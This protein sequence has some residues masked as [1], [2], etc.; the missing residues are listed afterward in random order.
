MKKQLIHFKFGR[1]AAISFLLA[2]YSIALLS[3]PTVMAQNADGMGVRRTTD[4]IMKQQRLLASSLATRP[5]RIKVESEVDQREELPQNPLSPATSETSEDNPNGDAAKTKGTFP[6]PYAPQTTSLEFTGATL[7]D[8]AAFPPDTMGAIGPTQFV[9][10]V[11]GRIRT[12]NKTTGVADG[13]LDSDMD[14]FF[15]LVMTPDPLNLTFT[16]DPHVRYDRLSGRW[17]VIIIDVQLL[18]E[19]NNRVLLAVSDSETITGSTVWTFFYFQQNLVSPAG[20]TG[21]LA[22]YPTLGID[23]NALYI[24]TNQFCPLPTY[25]SS[26]GF[27]VQKSS[28]LGAGPIVVHAFRNLGTASAAGLYTPQGVDNF[29]AS[30]PYGYFIG[31][32]TQT[33]GTLM[34]RRVSNAGSTSPTISGNIVVTVPT[35]FFPLNVPHKGNT[36]GTTGYLDGIDDRLFAAAI[37]NGRLWTAHNIGVNSSGVATSSPTR[38]AMRWYEIQNLSSTPSLRQS[39]TIFNNAGSD[40]IYYWMGTVIVSGQGHAAF[41]MSASNNSMYPSAATVGRLSGDSLGT[42]QGTPV[43]YEAGAG[44]YNPPLDDGSSSGA[45][46]WGDFSYTSLDPCDDMTMWTIQEYT[47]AT[48]SYGVRAVKLLAPPPAVLP[49]V[50]TA[51]VPTGVASTSVTITGTSPAGQGFYDPGAGFNCRLTAGVT[52]G[53]VVNS[54]TYTNPTSISLNLSTVAASTG[55]ATVTITNP[56]GQQVITT[57]QLDV[58]PSNDNF[59]NATIVTEGAPFIDTSNVSAATLEVGD[60]TATC[61]GTPAG[62]VW[63][64]YTSL[65][66]NVISLNTTGSD[67][68]T[69]LSV[70]TGTGLGALTQVVSGCNDNAPS[71]TTSALTVNATPGVT[72]FIR[73][74][75]RTN[76]HNNLTFNMS[77]ATVAGGAPRRNY[78]TTGTPILTWNRVTTATQYIIQ[79]SKSSTFVG[80]LAFT[81]TVPADHLS[82]QI[83]PALTEGI[84]YWRVSANGG[85]TWSVIDG[86]VVDLP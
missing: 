3:V 28:I 80:A 24:G 34:L 43:I 23:V 27:V 30:A 29:D 72:Y 52:N 75:S 25:S 14:G 69:V 15:S 10:A 33:F 38:D 21:C 20:D 77:V 65:G 49:G 78:F 26:A 47:N 39:G 57:L 46:R 82:V 22:D 11:N 41:G 56:D 74:S 8:T 64:K 4:S 84:Y 31:V 42:T 1:F 79:V 2:T 81:A 68:D 19:T 40:P 61:G 58:P 51:T 83:T 59:A 17:I 36:Q 71:V 37:R 67:Y 50:L 55:L 35:T 48:N 70:W 54:V 62:T 6:G 16:S 76:I 45:R 32:D 44:A 5:V 13:V 18:S 9:V 63:Y 85:A 7:A 60:P 53:V 66:N 86:F 73:V 12:F